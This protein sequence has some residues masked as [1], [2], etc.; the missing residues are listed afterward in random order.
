MAV[1]GMIYLLWWLSGHSDFGPTA[2]R[3]WENG[4]NSFSFGSEFLTL[5]TPRDGSIDDLTGG[6]KLRSLRIESVQ[7]TNRAALSQH[8]RIT[9]GDASFI[10]DSPVYERSVQTWLRTRDKQFA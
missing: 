3:L 10:N 6:P 5:G 7:V 9:V 1:T 2:V 4:K 8:K